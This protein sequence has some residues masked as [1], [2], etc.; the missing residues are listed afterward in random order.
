VSIVWI[1][2]AVWFSLLGL[3][4]ALRLR[5]TRRPRSTLDNVRRLPLGS[6]ATSRGVSQRPNLPAA[7][8]RS[9]T[10]H[11]PLAAAS[12]RR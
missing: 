4:V 3:F 7:H 6:T 9:V 5:A 10:A 12:P 11:G 8:Q 1:L 2:L